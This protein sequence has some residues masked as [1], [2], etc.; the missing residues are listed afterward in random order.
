MTAQQKRLVRESFPEIRRMSGPASLLFY[1]RLFELDPALRPLFRRDI[2]I[3]GR[4]LMDML[5]AMVDHI[6]DLEKLMPVFHAMGQRHV[7]Y[8]VKAEH[9]Q[10]V[11]NALIWAFGQVLGDDFDGALKGAWMSVI[12]TV[13]AGM[14]EGAAQL[15]PS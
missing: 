13:S 6:D 9:Y 12:D 7:G 15:S 11:S 14:Q 5:L 10:T 4:K 3:Q 2:E 8:G 1:G